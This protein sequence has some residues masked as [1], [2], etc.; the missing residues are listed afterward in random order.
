VVRINFSNSFSKCRYLSSNNQR[1]QRLVVGRWQVFKSFSGP[2]EP[3]M[4][5]ASTQKTYGIR[6]TYGELNFCFMKI[7]FRN[8]P[9][10][11]R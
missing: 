7:Y 6:N 3:I 11:I 10:T 1:L 4:N 8:F 2:T 5:Y 9:R